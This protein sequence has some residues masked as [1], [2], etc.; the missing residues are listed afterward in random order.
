M[1]I[2]SPL[3][4]AWSG[5]LAGLTAS[6]NRGGMYLRQRSVPVNPNSTAQQAARTAMAQV[7]T[8]WG[9][10]SAAQ[11]TAWATYAANV[12]LVGPLGSP[13]QVSG[14]NMY[15]RANVPR[16]TATALDGTAA[17]LARVDDAPTTFDVGT[18]TP[19]T[20]SIATSIFDINFDNSDD[21]ANEDGAAML[22]QFGPP[23]NP[24]INFF[25]APFRYGITSIIEGDSVTP[26][27]SPYNGVPAFAA[28]AGQK[29]FARITVTRADG[30][31]SYSQIVS[32]IAT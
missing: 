19:V 10:L 24:T 22:I 6:H 25:K 12:P 9:T 27:T 23:V 31:L 17:A 29:Q 16:I 2:S 8:A 5:S 14:Q 20:M 30:R 26:P 28:V 4:S 15:A 32:A 21:W 1:L 7:V 11:R 18:F 13:R 3:A